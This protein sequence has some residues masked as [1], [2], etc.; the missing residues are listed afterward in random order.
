[1]KLTAKYN[2]YEVVWEDAY[3]DQLEWTD[4]EDLTKADQQLCFSVGYLVRYD[5]RFV[6]L[7][8]AWGDGSDGEQGGNRQVIPR[9]MVREIRKLTYETGDSSASPTAGAKRRRM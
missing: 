9:S 4:V 3:C 2:L 6:V 1:M 8:A 7:I 5:E